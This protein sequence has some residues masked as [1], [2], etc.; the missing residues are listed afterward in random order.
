MAAGLQTPFSKW[1]LCE[2]DDVIKWKHFPRY[3]PFVRGIHQSPVNSSHKGQWR[4]AS[5]VS[6]ICAWINVW[7]NKLDAGDLRRHLA[8]YDVIVMK[9]RIVI[10]ISHKVF[11]RATLSII[12][13]R[14]RLRNAYWSSFLAHIYVPWPHSI[15]CDVILLCLHI[16]LEVCLVCVCIKAIYFQTCV[17]HLTSR[18]YNY[19]SVCITVKN[20]ALYF[21]TRCKAVLHWGGQQRSYN[22]DQ[23]Q[24][25]HKECRCGEW[26][27]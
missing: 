10:Q 15:N 21:V 13:L 22:T 24:N 6:V 23:H 8:H 11:P 16:H 12:W 3:W 18:F 1:F 2:K 26:V 5:V 9:C 7:V 14:G 27:K 17:S 20:N 25:P 19:L 4:G